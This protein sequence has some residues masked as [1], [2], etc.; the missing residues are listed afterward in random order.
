PIRRSSRDLEKSRGRRP[1]QAML[2]RLHSYLKRKPGAGGAL[3]ALLLVVGGPVGLGSDMRERRPY[4]DNSPWNTP[5]GA[6]PAIDRYS[7]EM[8][9]TLATTRTG[10]AI[11]SD[12]D[13]Y[14][15]PVYFVDGDTPRQ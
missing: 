3:L 15:Y 14:S 9:T 8:I 11:T 5:I 4:S 6:N 13:Q 12:P 7:I 2:R 10:G 1:V